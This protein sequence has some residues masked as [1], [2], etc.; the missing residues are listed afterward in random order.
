[1]KRIKIYAAALLAL[2]AFVL[3]G[4]SKDKDDETKLYL[5][6]SLKLEFPR[7][8]EPGFSKT[9]CIDTLTTLSR[10]DGKPIG[11][12]YRNVGTTKLDT[13]ITPDGK[14]LKDRFTIVVPDTLGEM[15][16]SF[17]SISDD[18]Y[19]GSSNACSFTVV[20]PGFNDSAS[21]TNIPL[22]A[23]DAKFTD[24]RDGREYFY[25]SIGGTDWM[26]SNLAWAGT[27]DAPAGIS[28]DGAPVMDGIFGRYYS[29][30]EAQAACPAGWRLPS[31]ED[32]CALGSACGLATKA[33]SDI[34]GL[35]G[36]LMGNAY[37]NGVKMWEFWKNVKITNSTRLSIL[38]VGYAV[39]EES[40]KKFDFLYQYA[41]LWSSEAQGSDSAFCRYIYQDQDILYRSAISKTGIYAS[42]RCV[43]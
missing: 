34:N 40:G 19:Y 28:Y 17:G 36:H 33:G 26:M 37:F 21:L 12:Y 32:W 14:V 39:D 11:Y 15:S 2:S 20:R 42:V 22:E 30:V 38:P 1:M 24:E 29:W 31:E 41:T 6:G 16:F 5:D 23:S 7:Y 43:R 27:K 10:E 13:L 35:A 3:A 25:N 4:C 8:V 18:V 9:F